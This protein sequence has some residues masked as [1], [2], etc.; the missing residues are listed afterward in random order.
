[1]FYNQ[2]LG[3]N[4]SI[5]VYWLAVWS[6]QIDT[7]RSEVIFLSVIDQPLEQRPSHRCLMCSGPAIVTKK[8]WCFCQSIVCAFR[9]IDLG[10]DK[11]SVKSQVHVTILQREFR[12]DLL[13]WPASPGRRCLGPGRQWTQDCRTLRGARR[14]DR[15]FEE[16]QWMI[17][18]K[19]MAGSGLTVPLTSK[20][21][22]VTVRGSQ[23]LS[24]E[25][26]FTCSADLS[27]NTPH[28]HL[29]LVTDNAFELCLAVL[30]FTL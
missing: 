5:V 28:V 24:T 13:A 3:N 29:I 20:H 25:C 16:L 12:L 6:D 2:R 17:S 8:R 10:A 21:C 26:V 19:R 15:V 7:M 11:G 1:M 18:F 14:C 30:N 9:S 22:T 23:V 27:W 4:L